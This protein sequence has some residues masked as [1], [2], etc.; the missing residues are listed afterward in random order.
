MVAQHTEGYTGIPVPD[1]TG[2]FCYATR[3]PK[4]VI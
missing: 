3:A 1:D 4:P 2:A